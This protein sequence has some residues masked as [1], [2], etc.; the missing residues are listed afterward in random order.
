MA[1]LGEWD[2][3]LY[4]LNGVLDLNMSQPGRLYL[5]PFFDAFRRRITTVLCS[6]A[7]KFRLPELA[8][9]PFLRAVA[10]LALGERALRRPPI[11]GSRKIHAR[12]L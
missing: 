11:R 8:W 7:L 6:F 9:D 10:Y 3:G 4:I 2:R 5:T 1:L 12:E